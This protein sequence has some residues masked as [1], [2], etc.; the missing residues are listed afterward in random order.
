MKIDELE[1]RNGLY[2]KKSSD[3][4]F[5][6]KVSGKENGEII[7]G[8][9]EGIWEEYYWDGQLRSKINYKD[10]KQEGLWEYFNKDGS[11]NKTET[12]K[13]GEKID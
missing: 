12:W 7:K 9:K 6:G 10:G 4:P 13:N 2:Y 1:F 3:K 11:L 5:T 8:Q